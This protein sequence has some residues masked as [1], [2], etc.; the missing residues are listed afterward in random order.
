M[1]IFNLFMHSL[2]KKEENKWEAAENR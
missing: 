2:G 1:F